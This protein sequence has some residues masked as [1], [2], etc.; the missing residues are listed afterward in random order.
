MRSLQ[1]GNV[2]SAL[3]FAFIWSAIR[4]RQYVVIKRVPHAN[5]HV[6]GCCVV[7]EKGKLRA[8][9]IMFAAALQAWFMC[10]QLT[11]SGDTLAC[12]FIISS[13]PLAASHCPRVPGP[14]PRHHGFTVSFPL[15]V[16]LASRLHK[17]RNR[18]T[19]AF[20]HS[21]RGWPVWWP[22]VVH[23]DVGSEAAA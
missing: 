16:Q 6:S 8:R 20:L 2:Q 1:L 12:S 4:C 18:N 3:S 17:R 7:S 10:H 22:S 14:V 21:A 9:F 5:S 23:F 19:T 13:P 11:S 15:Q